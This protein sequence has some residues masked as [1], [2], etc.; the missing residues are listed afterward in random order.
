MNK[1]YDELIDQALSLEDRQLLARHSEA[2]YIAQATGLFKGPWTWV[3]W[4]VYLTTTA[5]FIGV[6]WAFWRMLDTDNAID[7]VQWGISSVLLFQFTV[8]GKNF[9]GTHLEHNRVLRELKRLELQISLNRER[10]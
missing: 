6:I 3:M 1:K 9:M 4:L 7:A 10:S 2:G 5:A 8:M